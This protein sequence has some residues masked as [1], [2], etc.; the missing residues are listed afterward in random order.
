MDIVVIPDATHPQRGIL[1]Y[2]DRSY[3]CVLGRAGVR[4]DKH[5]GDGATPVGGFPL[6]YVLYRADRGAAPTTVLPVG[7][8]APE[9]G[10]CDASGDPAYNRPVKLPYPASAENMWRNDGLYDLVVVL[11][12]NNAPV[13][14][15]A[16][17]AIFMHVAPS[18]GGPTAG[19]I[20]LAQNDL[21]ELLGDI[22]AFTMVT[23]KP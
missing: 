17:S 8:I 16:G 15:G 11:G 5:E 4:A 7:T 20:A 10:W 21:R 1:T 13:V 12:Y 18:E 19:C 3:P 2:G 22:D 9:D 23:V 14:S 6:R